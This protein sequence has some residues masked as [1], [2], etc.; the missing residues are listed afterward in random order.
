MDR[1][2]RSRPR[3]HKS[4]CRPVPQQRNVQISQEPGEIPERE[5][6]EE[7]VPFCVDARTSNIIL[8]YICRKPVPE[9]PS[10]GE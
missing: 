1:A 8:A 7:K 10:T 3:R 9:Q 6:G 5:P 2:T 4:R